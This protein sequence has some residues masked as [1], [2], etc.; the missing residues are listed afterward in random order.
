[1]YRIIG[2]DG[3][4]YG[5]VS[6]EQLRQWAAQGRV[7]AETRML[8]E[9]TTGWRKM[10]EDPDFAFWLG[11]PRTIAPGGPLPQK[12]SALAITSL[13][14]GIISITG[15]ICCCYG[16]P[17]QIL[18]LIFAVAALAQI[19]ASPQAYTGRGLAIAGLAL[20]LLGILLAVVLIAS[21]G[22]F[23]YWHEM[24]RQTHRL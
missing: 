24:T 1:M 13:V 12:T 4:E 15:G 23:S 21:F 19:S 8:V 5:P 6:A 17:F 14:L 10:G 7:N 16:L 22:Q 11:G 9:G 18:G 20:C 2:A 3:R